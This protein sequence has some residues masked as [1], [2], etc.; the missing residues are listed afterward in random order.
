MYHVVSAPPARARYPDLYVRP[1]DFASQMSWLA[2]HGYHAVTLEH[3]YDSWTGNAR[4]PSHPIVLSFDDGYLSQY[5][6]ALP[7]LR[8]HQ[9]PGVLNLEVNFLHGVDAM[10]PWRVRRL[11]AA[12]WEID[13]HTLTHPDL[14]RLDDAELWRQVDGSRVALRTIFH[15]PVDFFCYPAGRYDARVIA[16]VKRAGFLGAT[17]TNYGLARPP[18]YYTLDRVRING[19]DGVHG[20][21]SKLESLPR[22][23][24]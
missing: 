9:W 15:V 20:F 16:A 12:G 21:A 13:A 1:S 10:R 2:Q 11:I 5:T 17:T 4:L 19:S 14:T 7:I 18:G 22:S 6:E 24:Y 3:V 8:A 23:P